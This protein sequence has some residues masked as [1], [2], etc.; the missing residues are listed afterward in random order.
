[1]SATG[2]H[3][4]ASLPVPPEVH[5]RFPLAVTLTLAFAATLRAQP[6]AG[7]AEYY[8]KTVRPVL[9]KN[10]FACHSHAAKKA[11]GGLMLD[12]HDALVKGGVTGAAFDSR[13]PEQSLIAKA[14]G[15]E[16]EDLRMPPKG[17]LADADRAILD[18]WLKRGAPFAGEIKHTKSG[19]I[20]DEDRNWW[21]YRPVVA[22]EPA[23]VA[24][25]RWNADPIDRFLYARLAREGLRPTAPADRASL[26]RRVTFDLIGLPPTPEEI[27]AFV[28]D[29]DPKAFETRVDKLLAS[30]RYGERMA[31]RW[32]DLARYG[33]SDG[34]RLDAY[35][36]SAWR[37]RDWVI[38]AFNRDMPYD[39]FVRE[40]LAGDQIR[41]DD[42][43][44]RIATGF[45]AGG[46]YEYNQSDVRDQCN[47][48][49]NE[50][51]DLTGDVFLAQ[52]I[53]CAKCHDH[54]FDPI[55]QKDYFRLRAFFEP[56]IVLQEADVSTPAE[57]EA[58][59]RKLAAWREATKQIREEI[60][61]FEIPHRKTVTSY[62]IGRFPKDVQPIFAKS[63][64]ERSPYEQQIVT[65]ASRQIDYFMEHL[66]ARL[67]KAADKDRYKELHQQLAKFDALKPEPLPRAHLVRDVGSVAPPTQFGK[68]SETV[69]PGY[70]TVI[71]PGLASVT[72]TETSTGRR[73]ALADWI[74][75]PTNP[76]TARVL[77]NRIWQQH[78][79]RGL[80]ASTSDFGRLGAQPTHP[81]LLDWLADTFVKDGWS[82]KKLHR[83]IVISAAYRQATA[84]AAA[85]M[86]LKKDPEN[87]LLWRGSTRRLEAEQ[88]RDALLAVTGKLDVA[89]GGPSVEPMAPR[90]SIYIKIRRNTH[91]PMLDVF[92]WPEGITSTAERNVTTTASQALL[93]L[94]SDFMRTQ[95]AALAHRVEK[96]E[97]DARID[98]LFRLLFGRHA[99]DEER[100]RCATFL[101]DQA[102][103]LPAGADRNHAVLVDLCLTLLNANEFLYVD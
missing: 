99:T 18:A 5:M 24:D 84:S 73:R 20:T 26:L 90:R 45:L 22:V 33:E 12:S 64:K 7:D 100:S 60:E 93:M 78:F 74:A 91:D 76:L 65:L 98:R 8:T 87:L 51:V 103:R 10:C 48:M 95:A 49:V 43:D 29:R 36:S 53:G 79:G 52:G 66:D 69:A 23:P 75:S 19:G 83:R 6:A 27:D 102:T 70:L 41:P 32:L 46:I 80:T 56:T 81:E 59:E 72:P 62:L 28:R 9:E 42:R 63:A 17:K 37:Y 57:R 40:Q 68:R 71:D 77:V 3:R 67:T 88:I 54:K 38:A 1:M 11:K 30:P 14:I 61:V 89:A 4:V 21:A 85:E 13:H 34:F 25:A 31:R 94:N 39:E 97:P 16:D 2:Y 92:D 101:E 47:N 44:A 15:Y 82:I 58:Y 35:R 50:L 55:L 96:D 86:A